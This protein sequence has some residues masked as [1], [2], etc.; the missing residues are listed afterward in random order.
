MDAIGLGADDS[1]RPPYGFGVRLDSDSDSDLATMSKPEN[2]TQKPDL[3]AVI[4]GLAH[5]G[6]GSQAVSVFE[7]F[8]S[9]N[10]NNPTKSRI[11]NA[12]GMGVYQGIGLWGSTSEKF[13]YEVQGRVQDFPRTV[14]GLH[15]LFKRLYDEDAISLRGLSR[16]EAQTA[17][18]GF[19][20][21]DI[22]N[23]KSVKQ[24][25]LGEKGGASKSK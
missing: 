12:L 17:A 18:L 8:L 2:E 24:D 23:I 14:A 19:F 1:F 7:E 5:G 25:R 20:L 9:S 6:R 11:P 15:N 4:R 10:K 22:E 13:R 21:Q 3:G 16:D